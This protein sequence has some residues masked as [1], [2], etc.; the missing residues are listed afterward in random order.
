MLRTK[1]G[2]FLFNIIP[3][4]RPG[5][6][7]VFDHGFYDLACIPSL[8]QRTK[9]NTLYTSWENVA[10][11]SLA[12][13][14]LLYVMATDGTRVFASINWADTDNF[15]FTENNSPTFTENEGFTGNGSS[16][17]LSTGWDPDT[18]AVN[19]TQDEGGWFIGLNNEVAASDANRVFGSTNAAFVGQ[20]VLLPKTSANVHGFSVNSLGPT[21]GS[22]VS[23][24]GFFHGRRVASNDLRLFKDGSQVGATAPSASNGLSSVDILIC[25]SDLNGSRVYSTS[26]VTCFAIGASLTGQE[27]ALYTAWNTYFTSL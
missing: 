14:D 1:S 10:G 3:S 18:N 19:F 17:Y 8:A 25:A 13:L 4:Y 22:A 5:M 12:D 6:S 21:V 15:S 9:Q 16:S 20:N 11:E 23:S 26:Q 2:I 24:I 27:S 7:K